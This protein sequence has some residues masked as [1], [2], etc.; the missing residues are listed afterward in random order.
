MI[1]HIVIFKFKKDLPKNIVE[2]YVQK[3]RDLEKIVENIKNFYV[4]YDY[5]GKSKG[6]E[7]GLSGIYENKQHLEDYYLHPQHLDLVKE[8]KNGIAEDWIVMDFEI[9]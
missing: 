4:G 6:Y 5:S 7:I 8:L 3:L 1:Q 2:T 9:N